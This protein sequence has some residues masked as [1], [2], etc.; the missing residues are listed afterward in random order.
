M[1]CN[2]ISKWLTDDSYRLPGPGDGGGGGGGGC[3][4]GSL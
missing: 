3:D 2:C 4:W 1:C